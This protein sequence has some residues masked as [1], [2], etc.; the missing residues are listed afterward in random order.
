MTDKPDKPKLDPQD[1]FDLIDYPC[2]FA[3]KAMCKADEN[4]SA[5]DYVRGLLTPMLDDGALLGLKSNTSRTGKF[6]SVTA[7]I[8]LQSRDELEAIYRLIAQSSRVVMTL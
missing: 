3:F 1:G 7:T 2:D 4:S 8:H 5:I 6:E